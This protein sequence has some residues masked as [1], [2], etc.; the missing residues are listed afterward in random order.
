[1]LAAQL[2]HEPAQLLQ[3]QPEALRRSRRPA[4]SARGG[5]SRPRTAGRARASPRRSARRARA[6]RRRAPPGRRRRSGSSC[7]CPGSPA[8]RTKRRSPAAAAA[9][10]LRSVP[11]A[12]SRPTNGRSSA[13]ARASGS[14][15]GAS[16]ASGAATGAAAAS[17]SAAAS[18]CSCSARSS[19]DGVE[20]SSSRSSTRTRSKHWSASAWLPRAAC[21]R[22]RSAWP[23]SRNGASSTSW[24][25][26][27]WA[28]TAPASPMR[29]R[30]L[31]EQLERLQAVLLLRAPVLL[32]PR[33]VEERQR[34]GS[35][36]CRAQS[37]RACRPAPGSAG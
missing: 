30:R 15:I 29:Q 23:D 17:S 26:A 20:P 21:A 22:M 31:R 37:A 19:G 9:S 28:R 11:S 4:R 5:R 16:V 1:M 12:S 18:T 2:R 6:R 24:R 25:A 3:L 13:R 34:A 27:S 10:S 7:R 35:R 8:T 36:R 14:A 33:R 32:E